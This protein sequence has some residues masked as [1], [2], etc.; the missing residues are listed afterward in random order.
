MMIH[1]FLLFLFQVLV[2]MAALLVS[3]VVDGDVHVAVDD[4]NYDV[5][6]VVS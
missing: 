2:L 1:E 3:A 5:L 6:A 4:N